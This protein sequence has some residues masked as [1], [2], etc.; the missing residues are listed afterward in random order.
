MRSIE[1]I[2][3]DVVGQVTSLTYGKR[4]PMRIRGEAVA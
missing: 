3:G 2:S 1:L 4:Q